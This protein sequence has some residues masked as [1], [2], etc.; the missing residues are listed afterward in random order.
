MNRILK[1]FSKSNLIL[2]TIILARILND[3]AISSIVTTSNKELIDLFQQYLTKS[4]QDLVAILSYSYQN[5]ILIFYIIVNNFL[6]YI[7]LLKF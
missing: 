3:Y 6:F 5:K 2:L 1:L 4:N 7:I